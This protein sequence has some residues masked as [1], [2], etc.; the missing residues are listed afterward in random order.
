MSSAFNINLFLLC[1]S[2]YFILIADMNEHGLLL[3]EPYIFILNTV[4]H[5]KKYQFSLLVISHYAIPS[6]V[7]TAFSKSVTKSSQVLV[8]VGFAVSRDLPAEISVTSS[9]TP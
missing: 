1:F 9:L 5:L 8:P 2:F 3:F 7:F 4:I 6:A